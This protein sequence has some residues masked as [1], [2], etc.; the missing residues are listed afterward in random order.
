[1]EDSGVLF[2]DP[3]SVGAAGDVLDPVLILQVPFDGFSDAGS[4]C[5]GGLPAKFSR[6]A[7]GVDGVTFVMAGTV[8][9]EC[10]LCSVGNGIWAGLEYIEQIADMVDDIDVGHLVVA[11]DVVY[12]A[13]LAGFKD[14]TDGGAVILDEEPITDLASVPVN[15][16]GFPCEGVVDDERDEFFW[17][18]VGSVVVGT[19]GGEYGESVGVVVGAD[20]VVAGGFTRG[21]RAVRHVPVVF[22][23]RRIGG[24]EGP[25]DLI[26]GDVQESERGFR[27]V[28]EALPVGTGCIEEVEGADHVCLDEL[29]GAVDGPI[30]VGFCGEINNRGRL[31]GG[32]E[33]VQERTVS[34]AAVKE[35]M[36]GVTLKRGEIFG[37]TCVGERIEIEDFSAV[38]TDPIEYEIGADKAGSSGDEDGWSTHES[39]GGR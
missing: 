39:E 30:D 17:K 18:V 35:E 31:M 7:C 38:R 21:V 13:E 12:L 16:E 28:V 22:G 5:F 27:G 11:A 2:S 6:D 15:G 19:V 8:F 33:L 37:I 36:V 32:E 10:Y 20:E 29:T 23:E 3:L 4:E 24:F 34:D 14:A 1:M 26:G 25:I 9:D